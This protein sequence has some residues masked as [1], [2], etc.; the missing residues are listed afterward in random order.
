MRLLLDACVLYPT[1]LRDILIETAAAGGFT[2]L[3][4]DRIL[5]EWARAAERSALADGPRARAEIALLRT[6]FPDASIEAPD[7]PALSLPDP[8]DI[9]VLAAAIHGGAEAIVTLNLR[10]FPGRTLARHG[11]MLR[12]PDSVLLELHDAGEIPVA[13]IA[14]AARARAE[15]LSGQPQP[16][17]GILKR[18]NLPRLGKALG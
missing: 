11:L 7:D 8:N 1:V 2:P 17:R 5:E 18:A 6:R 13:R 15:T 4:S 9:H 3:W 12:S 16:L 10:D 14:Q